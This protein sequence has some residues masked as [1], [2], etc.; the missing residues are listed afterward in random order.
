VV[1]LRI[2]EVW[3]PLRR[4]TRR[5]ALGVRPLRVVDDVLPRVRRDTLP[6]EADYRDAGCD[7][8][9]RCLTC[10]LARC[11]FDVPEAER[12][13]V[14]LDARDREIALLRERHGAPIWML[15]EYYGITRRTVFHVL[16]Q[17]RR[18]Q[19]QGLVP[20]SS[21]ERSRRPESPGAE[22]R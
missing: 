11:Q 3:R 19:D 6:E 22:A 2:E 4:V 20:S 21:A 8:Y 14:R 12:R 1:A 15:A 7:L 5:R 9:A 17:Q 13:R 18:Q 10:P 16:A